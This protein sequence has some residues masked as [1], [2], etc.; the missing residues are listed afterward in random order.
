MS[1]CMAQYQE[2]RSRTNEKIR[3]WYQD[4][5]IFTSDDFIF[6]HFLKRGL[7]HRRVTARQT[8]PGLSQHDNHVTRSL[9]DKHAF[10]YWLWQLCSTS[11]NKEKYERTQLGYMSLHD[12]H[13]KHDNVT[14][15][16]AWQAWQRHCMTSMPSTL[17]SGVG[18]NISF[19]AATASPDTMLWGRLIL[20]YNNYIYKSRSI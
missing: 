7:V 6:L 1:L 18:V 16:Q 2:T 20:I 17:V 11:K 15:W 13:D 4:V 8:L 14:A 3:F 12:K 19:R 9:H 5:V 10:N